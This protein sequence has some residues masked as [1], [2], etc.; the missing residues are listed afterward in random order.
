MG[1]AVYMYVWPHP[2]G[3]QALSCPKSPET[4]RDPN[5]LIDGRFYTPGAAHGAT[6]HPV[7]DGRQDVAPIFPPWGNRLPF[8]G[9]LTSGWLISSR[10]MPLTAIDLNEHHQSRC[11][12]L[13]NQQ[14]D[15]FWPKGLGKSTFM[16]ESTP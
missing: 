10:G 11:V 4:E 13:I 14:V 3:L 8:I 1:T 7:V 9:E 12:P 6:P 5:G 15:P 16:R 2:T